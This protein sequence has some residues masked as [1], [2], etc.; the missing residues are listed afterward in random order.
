MIVQ[1]EKME[2]I[3][4]GLVGETSFKIEATTA[5]AFHLL[6]DGL[7]SDKI[8][9]VIR[10]LTCNAWDSHVAAG[11]SDQPVFIHLPNTLEPWF[12][13]RD[14]GVGLSDSQ[15]KGLYSTYFASTKT[16]SNDFIGA[17]GL[18]SKSPFA[19]AKSFTITAIYDGI[20]RIYSA[21]YNEDDI[22]T[23]ALLSEDKTTSCNEIEVRV[24]VKPMDFSAFAS[25]AKDILVHFRPIPTVEGAVNFQL[26]PPTYALEGSNWKLRHTQGG[27]RAIMGN[28]AYPIDPYSI[29]NLSGIQSSILRSSFDIEFKIGELEISASRETLSYKKST[30]EAI[31]LVSQKILDEFNARLESEI[32][33]ATTEWHA[34]HKFYN[35]WYKNRIYING[36]LP[37]IKWREITIDS[38]DFD[39]GQYS[40]KLKGRVSYYY[41]RKYG[42]STYKKHSVGKYITADR[43]ITFI[44]N[45]LQNQTGITRITNWIKT[46]NKGTVYLVDAVEP[47]DITFLEKLLGVTFVPTSSLPIVTKPKPSVKVMLWKSCGPNHTPWTE[48]T[49]DI[50]NKKGFYVDMAGWTPMYG[51]EKA[52]DYIKEVITTA[53]NLGLLTLDQNTHLVGLRSNVRPYFRDN[54]NWTNLWDYIKKRVEEH[55]A[56]PEVCNLIR[57]QSNL[58]TFNQCDA[59]Y[60]LF[61]SNFPGERWYTKNEYLAHPFAV[62]VNRLAKTRSAKTYIIEGSIRLAGIFKIAIPENTTVYDFGAAWN[63]FLIKYPMLSLV[64][65]G[66]YIRDSEIKILLEYMK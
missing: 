59:I 23:I 5:K 11:K 36:F 65:R 21:F 17:L 47:E 39:I 53:T 34:R 29:Q 50:N 43:D 38:A 49:L 42:E 37:K 22:P 19:Y 7:Y 58:R 26:T 32:S 16:N 2:V 62:F 46:A 55:I 40:D 63:D 4:G 60:R 30:Q 41:F 66:G 6:S 24:P 9:A 61:C 15:V 56:K 8:R 20:Q 52:T 28:V 10:E 14:E 45:D 44:Y 48:T 64:I 33:S 13:V 51:D 18:G 3:K 12:S 54:P 27:A 1:K 25:K 57:E 31:K 35:L